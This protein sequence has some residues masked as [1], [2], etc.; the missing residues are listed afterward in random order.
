MLGSLRLNVSIRFRGTLVDDGAYYS[1]RRASSLRFISVNRLADSHRVTSEKRLAYS[2]SI[3]SWRR[4]APGARV[5]LML[6]LA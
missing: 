5:Y 3:G 2:V 4:L 6:R 1:D